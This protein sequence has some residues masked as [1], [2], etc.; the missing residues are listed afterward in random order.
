[1]RTKAKAAIV[2]TTISG[3]AVA[4]M[5]GAAGPALAYDSGGLHLEA[6]AQSPAYLVAGGAALRVSVDTSCNAGGGNYLYVAVTER[7]GN[8]IAT[9]GT[10]AALACNGGHVVQVVTVPANS[11]KAFTRGQAVAAVQI[12]GCTA[13]YITCGNETRTRT[14]TLRR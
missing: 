6:R 2:G 4:G 12:S 1:M 13:D 11:G 3:A 10:S 5:V 14:I 8:G 7:V 9:G